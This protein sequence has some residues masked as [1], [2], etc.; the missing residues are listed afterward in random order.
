MNFEVRESFIHLIDSAKVALIAKII[1]VI[2][3]IRIEMCS[4]Y[5]L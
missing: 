4:I 1:E 3:A 5:S 2:R